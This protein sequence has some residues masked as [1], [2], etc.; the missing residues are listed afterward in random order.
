MNR[1][2]TIEAVSKLMRDG[3]RIDRYLRPT[4]DGGYYLTD[5]ACYIGNDGPLTHRM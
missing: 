3:N 1:T 2:E 4:E 5:A